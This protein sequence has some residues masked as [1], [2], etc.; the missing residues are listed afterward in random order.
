VAVRN[1]IGWVWVTCVVALGVGAAGCGGTDGD[2]DTIVIT[3]ESDTGLTATSDNDTS[4]DT[5]VETDT[6]VPGE[7]RTLCQENSDCLSGWCIPTADGAVCTQGC[8]QGCPQ[9]WECGAVVNLATDLVTVC[10]DRNVT[11][12]HPCRNDDDC[13]RF[14]PGAGAV[15]VDQGDAGRFCATACEFDGAECPPGFNCDGAS[16]GI[17]GMCQPE[18]GECACNTLGVALAVGT[19]CATTNTLGS[20]VGT[21]TCLDGGLSACNAPQAVEEM[22][23]GADDDCDG[24]PDDGLVIG[25]ACELGNVFGA[26]PGELFCSGGE[27]QCLG[28]EPIA[29]ICDGQ[30]Q[31]CDGNT[32]EGFL[33]SDQDDIADCVDPDDDN[34]GTE[35]DADCAPLDSAISKTATETCGNNIDDN[36]D[37]ATDEPGAMG[38]VTYF[39]DVD[40]DNFG[41]E[42]VA[43]RCMCAADAANDFDV[44]VQEDCKDTDEF[45]YPN[46]PERCNTVDDNCNMIADEGVQA[47]CGGCVNIC[48]IDAGPATTPFDVGSSEGANVALDGDGYLVLQGSARTGTYTHILSGWPLDSSRWKRL[49]LDLETL[50]DS[51]VGVRYRTAATTAALT[52]AAWSSP[53]GPYP[54]ASAPTAISATGPVFQLEFTLNLGPSLSDLAS[55]VVRSF[56][57]LAESF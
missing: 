46:A 8:Q 10:L 50:Q 11:L 31:D 15:C 41:S 13:N 56:R 45:V 28:V 21:R 29:E 37:G 19:D 36:C 4:S 27:E 25:G 35:D 54:P 47:P 57:V 32:D 38:C 5:G 22:C 42:I 39:Q 18:T 30:D 26:C 33:D 49:F 1:L 23:N 17:D 7:F 14:T 3:T 51:S 12:C 6:T 2:S 34:D 44:L 52:A 55:P 48:L 16:E 9:G 40:G 20:C 24:V 53:L 43:G